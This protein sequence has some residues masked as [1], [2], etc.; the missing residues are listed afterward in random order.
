MG[1]PDPERDPR[2]A[3]TLI[4]WMFDDASQ[5]TTR[6]TPYRAVGRPD[7]PRI[8]QWVDQILSEIHELL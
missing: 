1:R 3:L 6:P 5:W 2:T 8:E 4:A 7:R